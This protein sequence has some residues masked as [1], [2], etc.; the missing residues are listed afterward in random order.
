MGVSSLHCPREPSRR[1]NQLPIHDSNIAGS[2]GAQACKPALN[3]SSFHRLPQPNMF[4]WLNLGARLH[5]ETLG[6]RRIHTH[7]GPGSPCPS[8][9]TAP[10]THTHTVLCR[11]STRNT[12][13]AEPSI[14]PSLSLYFNSPANLIYSIIIN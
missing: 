8:M 13:S 10:N 1:A 11:V 14:N 4:L 12:V 7:G 9:A 6:T 2:C 3:P 5:F